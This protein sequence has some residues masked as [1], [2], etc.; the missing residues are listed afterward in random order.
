M[1]IECPD[2]DG[3]NILDEVTEENASLR[4]EV[5]KLK[6]PDKC[7]GC[8]EELTVNLYCDE[9]M[10]AMVVTTL[11]DEIKELHD[12]VE[13]LKT[14]IAEAE[15]EASDYKQFWQN[16]IDEA[17]KR[18]DEIASLRRANQDLKAAI[19][20]AVDDYKR[21]SRDNEDLCAEVEKLKKEIAELK[22]DNAVEVEKYKG[23]L[24]V[25]QRGVL[26]YHKD[27][28]WHANYS[29]E[30]IEKLIEEALK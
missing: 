17:Q 16:A 14:R 22:Y 20:I 6:T 12:E 9:C 19:T 1:L 28:G 26:D 21:V 24:K 4:A 5:E 30:T 11:Q 27:L 13:G 18:G 10:T 29:L 3:C 8:G 2:P 7:V 15:K 25:A 23:A